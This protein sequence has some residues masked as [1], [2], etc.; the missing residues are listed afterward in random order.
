MRSFSKLPEIK[1]KSSTQL[2][3][4]QTFVDCSRSCYQS[5]E[6][7]DEQSSQQS[8]PKEL[9]TPLTYNC[10]APVQSQKLF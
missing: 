4:L 7:S 10:P 3:A 8:K 6:S 2:S 9:V 5:T 1:A